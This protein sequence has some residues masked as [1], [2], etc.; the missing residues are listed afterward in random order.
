M[1]ICGTGTKDYRPLRTLVTNSAT[2]VNLIDISVKKAYSKERDRGVRER[3]N[4]V[5]EEGNGRKGMY[6][7]GDERS[8][9]K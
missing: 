2:W 5:K 6:I 7:D 4:A 3:V 9:R 8:F 1:V